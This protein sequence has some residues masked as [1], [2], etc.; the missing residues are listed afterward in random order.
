MPDYLDGIIGTIGLEIETEN[1][2]EEFNIDN[3]RNTHDASIETPAIREAGRGLYVLRTPEFAEILKRMAGRNTVLGREF[4]S[5]VFF[6]AEEAR[7]EVRNICYILQCLGEHTQNLRAGVHVHVGWAYD[8]PILKRTIQMSIWLESLLFHLAGMGYEFR[9]TSNNSAY[10]RPFTLFGPPV[11][12]SNIG[13]V[14]MTNVD[15][16]LS[17][18]TITNFWNRYGGVNPMNPP[19]RYTPQ[20]YMGVNLFSIFLH[21]TL[22]FRMFNTTLNPDY[23]M[24]VTFLCKGIARLT[25]ESSPIP[26]EMNSIYTVT[27]KEANYNTLDKLLSLINLEPETDRILHEILERS[28]ITVLQ[29]VFVRT[30]LEDKRVEFDGRDITKVSNKYPQIRDYIDPGIVDVHLLENQ[31]GQPPHRRQRRDEE[32]EPRINRDIQ[33][34][35]ERRGIHRGVPLRIDHDPRVPPGIRLAAEHQEIRWEPPQELGDH[36]GNDALEERLRNLQRQG[37]NWFVEN[38]HPVEINADDLPVEEFQ[39]H[40]DDDD[41]DPDEDP[42]IEPDE[43]QE[44]E[45]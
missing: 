36:P 1:V 25:L 44:E 43:D 35:L 12:D 6:E 21:K 42:D 18:P 34:E 9:G 4:V 38:E 5:P 28:P 14:Q 32:E 7:V 30:H 26:D 37:G 31:L 27:S 41:F 11:V 17:A 15:A 40:E 39:H 8:L 16:L 19:K 22:E 45:H 2:P 3:W 23:I 24:A 13:K 33:E 10:C 29:E 20:R